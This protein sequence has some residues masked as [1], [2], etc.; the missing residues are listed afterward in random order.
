MD[1]I[2]A[3]A[4]FLASIFVVLAPSA[5]YIP[6]MQALLKVCAYLPRCTTP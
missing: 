3:L 4:S 2:A 6:Q 1:A 5:V